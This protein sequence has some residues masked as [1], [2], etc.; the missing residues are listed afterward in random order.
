MVMFMKKQELFSPTSKY[1]QFKGD[2]LV[3]C[4]TIYLGGYKFENRYF[5]D[6]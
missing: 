6:F 1:G 4:D 3:G 5:S 2:Y